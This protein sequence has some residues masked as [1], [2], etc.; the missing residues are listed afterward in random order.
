VSA[1]L[2][3]LGPAPEFTG[4]GQWFNTPGGRPLSLT[5]LRGHVVL[6]DFWTYTCINCLRTLP[7]VKG[8]Y[9]AYHPYGLEIVGVETPEFTF[10]QDAGNVAQAIHSDGLRYPVVQDNQYGTWNA[11]GNQYWPAEYLIDAQGQVRHTQFGEG[12]YQGSE[13]AIRSLLRAAGARTLPR[14][15]TATAVIPSA[16]L[17]T[18]ETYLDD[19]RARGFP[20]PLRAGTHSYAGL[21]HPALNEFALRGTWSV[22]SQ[23]STPQSAGSAIQARFQA[24]KVYLVLTSAANVPRRV[25]I[26]LDGKPIAKSSAGADVHGSGLTV[27]GQRLYSLVSRRR[28]EPHDLEVR[29]PPGV[30][31]YSFTFG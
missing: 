6:V 19:Q 23:S 14:P 1:S 17:A 22:G 20:V 4:T 7:F 30:S 2:P 31:A 21:A 10:E 29:V 26:L 8:L 28:A 12:D 18:P 11:Y 5:G 3:N 27:R 24:A 15:I 25:Q 16:K 9:A 13:A